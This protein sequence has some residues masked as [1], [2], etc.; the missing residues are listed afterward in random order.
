MKFACCIIIKKDNP[1]LNNIGMIV[2]FQ[3]GFQRE[4][5]RTLWFQ[6]GVLWPLREYMVSERSIMAFERAHGF[7]E[8]SIW[9]QRG[10]YMVSV[11]PFHG[12]SQRTA[13]L[14]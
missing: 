8:E 13:T 4:K 10:E 3:I 9:F 6:R 1:P 14:I 2:W 7:R 5:R 12:A 11:H